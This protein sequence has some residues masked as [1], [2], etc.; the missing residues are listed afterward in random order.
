MRLA[1]AAALGLALFQGDKKFFDPAV[2][3]STRTFSF[4]QFLIVPVRV[5]VLRSEDHDSLNS[6]LEEKD[7]RRIFRKVNRI[8]NKAGL[9]MMIESLRFEDAVIPERF[10]PM[11]TRLSGYRATRPADSRAAGMVHVYYIHLFPIN[12]VYLGRDAI[13]VKDTSRL[14]EVRGGVDE[15]IPRVTSH[16]I[17]HAMSLG[18]RQDTI[19]LLASG[20]TGWSVNDEEIGKVRAWAAAQK[21]ALTPADALKKGHHAFLAALPGT[22]K[23]KTRAIKALNGRPKAQGQRP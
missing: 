6:R 23:I 5:H 16:E 22:S 18:H 9:G 1:L 21:W 13:F 12:G 17:G 19:N 15:P 8:W 2:H 20:T 14:R 10:D 11:K 4:D 3:E 7:V